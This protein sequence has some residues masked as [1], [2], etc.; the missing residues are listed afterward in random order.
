MSRRGSPAVAV[1]CFFLVVFSAADEAGA[2]HVGEEPDADDFTSI[3]CGNT[4]EAIYTDLATG[5]N[6]TS[7]SSYITTGEAR[8]ISPS[9]LAAT[10]KYLQTL[11]SFP[12][13]T[14]PPRNCYSLQAVKIQEYLIRVTFMHGDYDGSFAAGGG[15]LLF[16]LYV[17]VNLCRTVNVTEVSR[18]YVVEVVAVAVAGNISVC[19]VDKGSGTP[20]VS[21]VE[22]RPVPDT[23]MHSWFNQTQNLILFL[24]VDLGTATDKVLRYPDDRVDRL[25]DPYSTWADSLNFR[26][27]NLNLIAVTQTVDSDEDF[28][29]PS[30]VMQT[31]VAPANSSVLEFSWD[32]ASSGATDNAFYAFLHF[33]ELQNTSRSFNIYL[34]GDILQANFTPSPLKATYFPNDVPLAQSPRYQWT[35]SSTGL[36]N[37]PPILNALEVYTP[38]HLTNTPT[39]DRDAAAIVLIRSDYNVKRN[40]MGDAC[41]PVQ[42]AW[43]GLNCTNREESARIV[44]I[45]LSSS[46]LTG[47]IS[48]SFASLFAMESLDLSGN[49]LTGSIPE[50]L[51][52]LPSLRYLNLSGNSLN[53]DIPAALQQKRK[54][55]RLIFEFEGNPGL[56]TN[57]TQCEG[58]RKTKKLTMPIIVVLCLVSFLLI[59]VVIFMVWRLRKS[60]GN[61]SRLLKGRRDNPLQLE[62]REF[63]YSELERITDNFKNSIGKG[64][65]GTVYYGLL[66][67]GTQVAVK[68]RSQSSSQGTKEFLAEAL[69]LIR[70]HHKNLLALVGYCMD[71][72]HLA[73]VYEYMSQGTLHDHLRDKTGRNT[74]LSWRQRLQIAVEAAQGL[75]YLHKGCKP[76]LVHRDVKTTNILLSETF[77]AKIADFGLSKAYQNDGDSHVS[78]NVVGTP[79]YLDPEYYLSYQLSEKSDVYSF[80][81]VLLELITGQPPVIKAPH[82]TTLIQWVQQRLATGNIEDVVDANLGSQY[83]VNSIWKAADVALRCTSQTSHQRPSMAEVVLELKESL[84]LEAG[85]KAPTLNPD[86]SGKRLDTGTLGMSQT[87]AHDDIEYFPGI[88]PAAR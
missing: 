76:P 19:L 7:D 53:G 78:T 57:V 59:F 73:L 35:L 30:T 39:D 69:N 50:E 29:E 47:F 56:C 11:R 88:S 3:N 43:E 46:E 16:D 71:G 58:S 27:A 8:S 85:P 45:N 18:A 38:L 12:N 1:W 33:A 32:F 52:N 36:S 5:I 68:L 2:H 26:P 80:G 83:D 37:L 41:I 34:N 60:E 25:W 72:D 17:D 74:S 81:V 49:K 24:R 82:N 40:W 23:V 55:G 9:L 65:F 64:A 20:F 63:T 67:D 28:K 14:A 22:L 48:S 13:S 84:S 15:G 21:A 51:G 79:G 77:E 10:P 31:A 66:E 4:D 87:S 54:E 86:L 61:F 6:Y 42:Y 44:G 70:I 62:N 75:D